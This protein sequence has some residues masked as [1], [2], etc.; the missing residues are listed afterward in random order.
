MI[1]NIKF[2]N[3]YSFKKEQEI[4]FLANKKSGYD[5]FNSKSNSQITKIAGFIGA[6]ASGKTNV[7]RLFS[8]LGYFACKSSIENTPSDLQNA[9]KKFFYNDEPSGFQIEFELDNSIYFYEFSLQKTVIVNE[10]LYIKKMVKGSRKIEIYSRKFNEIENLNK[11]YFENFPIKFLKNIRS[12]ISLLSFLKSHYNIEIVNKVFNY[13]NHRKTNINEAGQLNNP[14]NQIVNLELYL[15]DEEIKKEMEEF[16][17]QFDLGLKGF[18]I[19]KEVIGGTQR[20]SVSGIHE[21]KVDNNQLA[22]NY[23]S[24]GTQSLFFTLAEILY[25]LKN[26]SLVIIDE[27]ELGFH[28]EALIKLI[29]YFIEKNKDGKA[30]LLFSSNSLVFMNTFDMHQI[31]LVEKNEKGESVVYRLNKIKGVRPDENF[32]SKYMSGSYGAFPK[33]RT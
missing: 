10:V 25:A 33:I 32:Q 19:K 30:Q 21:S 27:I 15:Q 18:N 9:Y 7:M 6:N 22:F 16:I 2:Y 3:F 26:N 29:S 12:D 31:Y 11:N 17:C 1:R 20:I 13:F 8:F 28:P 14:Q 24:R 5:Y 23:E 4:S